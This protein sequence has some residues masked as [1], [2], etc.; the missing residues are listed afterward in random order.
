MGA[1]LSA[2]GERVHIVVVGGVA[3]VVRGIRSRATAD[4][5]VIARGEIDLHGQLR[6]VAPDPLPEVLVKAVERVARDYGLSVDWLNTVIGKQWR[7]GVNALPP[8]L[9]AEVVWHAIGGLNV[10]IAGRRSLIALKLYAAAD[11]APR[12][13]HTQDLVAL[14]PTDEE[15]DEAAEWA[16]A[17]D[18][19]TAC[20][21]M[22]DQVVQYVK[23]N[24]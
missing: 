8:A 16:R 9:E 14:A 3:I 11:T 24:R 5:D 6:L 15:L 4:V 13:V 22:V 19:T 10:G 7:K 23:A 21:A 18:A 1:L 12:S 2:A 20:N 17:Q